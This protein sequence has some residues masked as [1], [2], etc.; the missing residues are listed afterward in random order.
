V[1]IKPELVDKI[2]SLKS[3]LTVIIKLAQNISLH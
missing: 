3:V 2:N 1:S